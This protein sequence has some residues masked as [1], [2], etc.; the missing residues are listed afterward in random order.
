MEYREILKGRNGLWENTGEY[1]N[2]PKFLGEEMPVPGDVIVREDGAFRVV[3]RIFKSGQHGILL[4]LIDGPS[5]LLDPI[6]PL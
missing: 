4:E 3:G 6:G 2:L 1:R 5:D